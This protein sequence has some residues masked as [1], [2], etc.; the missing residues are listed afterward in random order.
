M[1]WEIFLLGM[2]NRMGD[3]VRP[4]LAIS[5]KVT[6]AM[7]RFMELDYSEAIGKREK[8]KIESFAMFSIA[9]YLGGLR[10]ED[11]VK[12]DLFGLLAYFSDEKSSTPPFVPITLIGKFKGETAVRHHILPLA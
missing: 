6:G 11:I 2:H 1:W 4:D 12:L 7:L 3:D 10:G 9:G 8:A 5:L